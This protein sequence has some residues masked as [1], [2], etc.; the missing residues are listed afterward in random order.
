[1]MSGCRGIVRSG[2]P[3]SFSEITPSG[4]Q[5]FCQFV[6]KNIENKDP[7]PFS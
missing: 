2:D 4:L 3:L 7:Q 5:I 1:M 6:A